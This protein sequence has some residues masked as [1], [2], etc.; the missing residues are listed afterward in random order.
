[1]NHHRRLARSCALVRATHPEPTFAVT[2]FATAVA[3]VAGLGPA[4]T[5]LVAAAVLA[6]QASVG[7]SNDWLDADIDRLAGRSA[8]PVV[9]G[10][11]SARHLAVA[12]FAALAVGV[13]LSFGLGAR[14]GAVQLLALVLAWS[15]NLR[16]KATRLSGVPYL[17]AF[18]LVPVLFVAT[19]LPHAPLPAW[20]IPLGAGLLG[21]AGH[22]SNT[23]PDTVADR[24]TGVRGLPQRCGAVASVLISAALVTLAGALL[25][26]GLHGAPAAVAGVGA[27]LGVAAGSAL[28]VVR[29]GHV[30]AAF[31]LALL[32]A[33]IV[34]VGFVAS[35][36]R[37]LHG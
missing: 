34:V 5:V 26:W 23:V 36:G 18:S 32:A 1:M 7:W 25:A 31:R 24:R 3:A 33:G 6:G 16:W 30:R 4:R 9:A 29:T 17:V 21:L 14:P 27:A 2:A 20:Q 11:L 13:G 37:L 10:E 28:I 15:Y 8:K 22:F 12:A 35:G 19:S